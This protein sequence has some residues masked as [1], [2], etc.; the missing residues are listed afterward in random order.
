MKNKSRK[1]IGDLDLFA[2][3]ETDV[4]GNR[5]KPS[6]EF[7]EF[8]KE[9]IE[10]SI[11]SR[12]EEQVNKYPDKIA[13]VSGERSLTYSSLNIKAN[14]LADWILENYDNKYRLC[15]EEKIRYQRQM[16]L[17]GWGIE[18]QE[19]LKSTTVFA[20]GAGGSGSS[21]IMQLA[22]LGIGTIIVCDNDK[23]ELSNLNRQFLHD[24]SRIGMNKAQSAKITLNKMN[25][26]VN[27]IAY[28]QKITSENVYEL[29]GDSA[30]IFD[31]I[32]DLESK[33]VLSECAV[34]KKIPHIISSMIDFNSYAAIFHT[35][36]T[37]C[38]HCLYDR[39]VLEEIKEIQLHLKHYESSPNSVA[40]P[41][42][43]LS[44]GFALNEALKIILNFDN[45][46]YNKYFLFNQRGTRDILNAAGYRQIT[47]PFSKH[48]K[49]ICKE[50]GF[51]W[52]EGWR[53]NFVEELTIT[54]DPDCILCGENTREKISTININNDYK[55]KNSIVNDSKY[56]NES[57]K[58]LQTA[59][60]LFGHNNE[61]IGGVLGT[62]KAG[63]IYVPL[64]PD[65]PEDRL[66]LM[67][68]DSDARIIITESKYSNLAGRIRDKVNKRI[69]VINIHEMD[70]KFSKENTNIKTDPKNLAYILYTSGSTGKPKGVMQNHR[71]VLHHT[72][73]Y[74]NAL[75]INANDRLTLFSSYCFDA[76][77]MDIYGALLNGATLYPYDVKMV[78]NFPRMA[79]WLIKN[80][81]TIYHSI[82]T[83]YRYFIDT[84]TPGTK[85]PYLRF[86]VLGGEAVFKN[87]VDNY[88]KNF[89]DKC[90]FVNGLGPTESTLTLQY[91]ID[92]ETEL[93]GDIVPVGTPVNETEVIL[94]K[95][96]NEETKL[97]EVGEIVYKSDYLAV[98]YLDNKE[99][100]DEVFITDPIKGHGRVYRSGDLGRRM[101]DGNIEYAGRKDLQVKISG[102]RIEVEEIEGIL[103]EII[104]VK[105]SIAAAR[106]DH[107]EENYLA[108][109]FVK[110]KNVQIDGNDLIRILKEKLPDYM[111]PKIFT[112]LESFPLTV[113]GKIDR[114]SLPDPEEKIKSEYTAPRDEVEE[115]L[116]EIW[117]EVLG[118]ETN[119]ISIDSNF[120]E[121][122]GQSFKAII[123]AANVH[124][125][126]NVQIS[127][128]DLFNM[129]SIREL[130]EFI[131]GKKEDIYKEI[132]KAKEKEFFYLSSAQ[133]RVYFFQQI[134]PDTVSY[135]MTTVMI[136][137]GQLDKLRVEETFRKL[138]KRH[139]ILRTSFEMVRGQPIQNIH[140][141][142]NFEVEYYEIE[143]NDLKYFLQNFIKPF[144]LGKI[145]LFR[146]ALIKI[147]EE[148]HIVIFDIHHI[149]SDAVS[150]KILVDD[151]TA[152]YSGKVL[153]PLTLQYKDYSEWQNGEKQSK[154]VKK[155][156]E[157]W[158]NRFQGETPIL[159]LP[160]DYPRAEIKSYEGSRFNFAL[161][162]EDTKLI[163]KRVKEEEV[164]LF[165]MLYAMFSVFLSRISNQDDIIV[166]TPIIGR[167]HAD[168]QN[169]MG[170]FINTLALRSF[171]SGDKTFK[172]FLIE[173]KETTLQAFE[174]QDYQFED[175]VE[176]LIN[177]RDPGRN[178][179]FDV[180]FS[181]Q[182]YENSG[183]ELADIQ[184]KGYPYENKT[185]QFDLTLN[186]TDSDE[187]LFFEFEYCTK[188]FERE[189]IELMADNFIVLVKSAVNDFH[190]KIKNLNLKTPIEKELEEVANLEFNF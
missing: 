106:K 89:N 154:I 107:N 190:N 182:N 58:Y 102:F 52:D 90:L 140:D 133:K 44:T 95:K 156:E 67:L 32:D 118:I 59:A 71:N 92:K 120:F 45:P 13:S 84:L 63:K 114:N 99:K 166:G 6:N 39:K 68:K 141:D 96:N 61:M 131:K 139:E 187:K 149:I 37:P 10:Q 176:N 83:V 57:T 42:L 17:Y 122:G 153:T 105:K 113:T 178:P 98:G 65:C 50:Q 4:I 25:P 80:E 173:V 116:T 22:L 155:Q 82:P 78:G 125:E 152:L 81:L 3:D 159:N 18:A 137:E 184:F 64:D 163:K 14:Q 15:H 108:A 181:V 29:V 40:S 117:S 93:S 94:I 162:E 28:Q 101:A 174:N 171:P 87:D 21:L 121:L 145:P 180:V 119:E 123:L 8:K 23:V 33:F 179:L 27:V 130:A 165:M 188:L 47:Y 170:I 109:Y 88:K 91:F 12:F 9:S 189:T 158:L 124:K 5:V 60:L 157:Y 46:A 110:D 161:E 77:I 30:V 136:A 104:G 49:K 54:C 75:H 53:G 132:T 86:I 35:P 20:A 146:V 103:D 100:T 85:F 38:F 143:E 169:V 148:K 142:I 26:H 55:N 144:D 150:L 2:Y 129:Q 167:R 43:F 177:K 1:T 175:L 183:L 36:Q 126:M 62:L 135:N 147:K 111:I 41:S 76:A 128:T 160:T 138:L 115:K 56:L 97:F 70:E 112:E 72:R 48:F 79:N 16:L 127:L 11:V 134:E 19:K 66:V 164:T 185:V 7:L 151:F 34:A 73:I 31:N 24:E 186:C 74:T 51:D 168:I 69:P 172:Q